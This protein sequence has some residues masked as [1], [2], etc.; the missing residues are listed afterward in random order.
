MY[1]LVRVCDPDPGEADVGGEG[2]GGWQAGEEVWDG[3][4]E[5]PAGEMAFVGVEGLGGGI[6]GFGGLGRFGAGGCCYGG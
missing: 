2:C 1:R 6:G 3:F 4:G 5:L